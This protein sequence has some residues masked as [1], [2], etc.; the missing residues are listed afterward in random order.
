MVPCAG[1]EVYGRSK[2]RRDINRFKSNECLAGAKWQ[3]KIGPETSD[4]ARK[5]SFLLGPILRFAKKRRLGT[6]SAY[7]GVHLEWEGSLR[8]T[9]N[10]VSVL[11][12]HLEP[13]QQALISPKN[14]TAHRRDSRSLR[15][16]RSRACVRQKKV[17]RDC[18]S[19]FLTSSLSGLLLK[20]N[21][22]EGWRENFHP[23]QQRRKSPLSGAL[24]PPYGIPLGNVCIW[25]T[26]DGMFFT[27]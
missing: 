8:K 9:K 18:I 6:F 5:K 15:V 20:I 14:F 19:P 23:F 12:L 13:T 22:P 27:R 10:V 24:L 16:E 26:E 4:Y 2:S 7:S 21:A 3:K 17:S 11:L 25:G 1:S